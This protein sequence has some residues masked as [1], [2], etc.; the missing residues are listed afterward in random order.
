MSAKLRIELVRPR[1]A[2]D[3][4]TPPGSAIL[5]FFFA[6]E[7]T[8]SPASQTSSAAPTFPADQGLLGGVF[9]RVTCLVGAA[10]VTKADAAPVATQINGV[11]MERGQTLYFPIEP[12][13]KLAAI[14][15]SSGAEGGVAAVNST[16]LSGALVMKVGPGD[17]RSISCLPTTADGYLLLLDAAAIPGDG[18]CQP[19]ATPIPVVAGIPA[20]ANWPAAPLHFQTGLV[21]VF[22]TDPS[23]FVKAIGANAFFSGQVI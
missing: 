3:R 18:A 22:S 13:Q 12:G 1:R 15:A 2:G 4:N 21:A 16:A 8:L 17:L 14:E 10:I 19:I 5:D 7:L 11:R 23:P 6:E 9:A 20:F